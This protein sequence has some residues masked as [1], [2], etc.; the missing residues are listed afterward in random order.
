MKYKKK[1]ESKNSCV[2]KIKNGR[3]IFLSNCLVFK[4][5]KSIFI[6]YQEARG[7]LTR[8]L[9]NGLGIR[10]TLSKTSIVNPFCFRGISKLVQGIK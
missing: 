2:I 6:K 3:I 7:L 10:T 4:G 5:K 9:E 1:A 8:S